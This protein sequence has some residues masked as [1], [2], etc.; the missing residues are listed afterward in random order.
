MPQLIASVEGVEIK[1]VYLTKDR[2]TLG[3]RPDNDIVLTDLAVSGEHCRFELHGLADV[4]VHDLGSTNG[5]FLNGKIAKREQLHDQDLISIGRFKIQYL[6]ASEPLLTTPTTAAMPLEGMFVTELQHASL[7]VLTGSSAGLEMPVA[8]AV[9][10]FGKPGVAVVS[11]AHRRQGYFISLMEGKPA[12]TLNGKPIGP[13]A[14]ALNDQDVIELAG[15][16]MQFL[17]KD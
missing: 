17:L 13:V 10:T 1:Q 9:A 14:I 12:P 3:R 2:T 4:Y 16:S 8:K 5:T 15:T 7:K 11:I 6:Q